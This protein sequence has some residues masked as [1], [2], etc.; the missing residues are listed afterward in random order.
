MGWRKTG[1]M[2]PPRSIQVHTCD[3]CGKDIGTPDGYGSNYPYFEITAKHHQP[4]CEDD[5]SMSTY[6]LCSLPCLL[7]M[8]Q[9]LA[10][11]ERV[12]SGSDDL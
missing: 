10:A 1:E 8:A 5:G 9:R 3:Q 4:V 6:S 2:F 7:Q 11:G 12:P